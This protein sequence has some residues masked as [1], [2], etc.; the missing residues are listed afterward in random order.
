MSSYN[1]TY[2]WLGQNYYANAMSGGPAGFCIHHSAGTSLNVKSAFLANSTSAHYSI[3]DNDIIQYV[4]D[5]HGC[6]HAGAT[7]PNRNLISIENV[8]SGGSAA[9]WPVSETTVDTLVAFLAD[10]CRQYGI[11]SLV[12]GQN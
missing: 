9:G 12:R 2:D 6:W 5:V 3:K 1:L 7:W 4:E 8:N 11:S 10:K